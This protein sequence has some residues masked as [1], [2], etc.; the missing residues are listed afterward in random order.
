MTVHTILG[1]DGRPVRRW[2]VHAGGECVVRRM[3]GTVVGRATAA[4]W[5]EPLPLDVDDTPIVPFPGPGTVTVDLE[6]T[7]AARYML[8][9]G[10]ILTAAQQ[11]G[12]VDLADE[13]NGRCWAT[14]GSHACDL[15]TGHD[16]DIHACIDDGTGQ[17]YTGPVNHDT[18]CL[19]W[20]TTDPAHA[21]GPSTPTP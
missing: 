10:P 9:L 11:R 14:W 16:G 1:P 17:P 13:R 18:A 21:P 12:A 20:N 2:M 8:A 6:L 7:D 15:P 4:S 5:V 3:D 19:I